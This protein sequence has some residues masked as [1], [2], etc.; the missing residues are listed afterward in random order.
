[1]R[2]ILLMLIVLSLS[3]CGRETPSGC[4]TVD[5]FKNFKTARPC[6]YGGGK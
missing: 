4:D 1:M 6:E 5:S 2:T 3:A